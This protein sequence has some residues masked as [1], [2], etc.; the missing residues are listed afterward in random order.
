MAKKSIANE[1]VSRFTKIKQLD[2]DFLLDTQAGISKAIA[3]KS[4]GLLPVLYVDFN[5]GSGYCEHYKKYGA[6]PVGSPIRAIQIYNKHGFTPHCIFIDNNLDAIKKLQE[7]LNSNEFRQLAYTCDFLCL[8]NMDCADRVINRILALKT[9]SFLGMMYSDPNG[10]QRF[11]I[12]AIEK[13]YE[14]LSCLY[15]VDL[16]LNVEM[17]S[18]KRWNSNTLVTWDVPCHKELL[19]N[20]ESLI[21]KKYS[22]LGKPRDSR[23]Q[24]HFQF[25]TNWSKAPQLEK[26][27]LYSTKPSEKGEKILWYYLKMNGVTW[28]QLNLDLDDGQLPLFA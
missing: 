4:H 14:S 19:L 25:F 2:F 5:C 15:R 8:D 28:K 22:F 11:P 26:I 3:N 20:Y 24:W 23:H 17:T 13:I 16:L 18:L 12:K 7:N 27:N 1:G 9:E 6:N 21:N 10:N